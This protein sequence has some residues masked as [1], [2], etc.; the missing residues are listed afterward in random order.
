[1]LDRI[2]EK[3]QKL[4]ALAQSSNEH[5]ARAAANKASALLIEYNLS[6]EQLKFD[7]TYEEKP[8]TTLKRA[9]RYHTYILNLLQDFFFV[10]CFMRREHIGYTN[11]GR[12]KRECALMLVG[13]PSNVAVAGYIF[14]FLVR[15]F[16]ELWEQF[17][18][19]TGAPAERKK[20]YYAGLAVGLRKQLEATRTRVQDEKG[21]VLV[22]DADLDKY[23]EELKLGKG[24]EGPQLTLDAAT[25]HA[26]VEQGKELTLQ[27][28]LT[29]KSKDEGLMLGDKK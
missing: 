8:A 22:R 19:E 1:M 4:L 5:E 27:A 7:R 17:R 25:Y 24:R 16:P 6:M 29:S 14:D 21:L 26:G 10:Q 20:S 11:R 13:T 12:V 23:M 18:E 9:E 3:I 2:V 28:A 15:K